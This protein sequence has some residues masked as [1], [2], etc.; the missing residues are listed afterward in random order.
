MAKVSIFGI[1]SNVQMLIHT[2]LKGRFVG[3][4]AQGNKYYRG[5]ARKGYGHERRWVM[6]IDKAEASNVPP[7][8]HGWLHHQTDALPADTGRYRKDWQKPHRPNMTG[9]K[10]AWFPP[11]HKDG[12]REAA[13]SDYT[14]WQ[15]PR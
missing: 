14:P 12:R 10:L 3:A 6:Y 9:T 4:D 15:P 7:E 1:L 2:A 5:K 11:G 13:T 8:W